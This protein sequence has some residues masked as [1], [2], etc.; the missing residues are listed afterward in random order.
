MSKKVVILLVFVILLLA[1]CSGSRASTADNNVQEIVVVATEF[2]FEPNTIEVVANRPA[3]IVLQNNGALEHDLSVMTISVRNVRENSKVSA[4]HDAHMHEAGANLHV[5][6]LMGE[7]GMV[8][9]TATEPGTYEVECTIP[10]HKEAGMAA[11]LIVRA[12]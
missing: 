5:G 6:V 7:T 11:T 8:D 3:R 10:G 1:A 9:F 4:S 12:P 2:K